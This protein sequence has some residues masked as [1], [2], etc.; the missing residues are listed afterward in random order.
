VSQS[1]IEQ[2]RVNQ[3]FYR[4]YRIS[5]FGEGSSWSFK[6]SPVRMDLPPPGRSIFFKVATPSPVLSRLQ[7]SR[8][9]VFLHGRTAVLKNPIRDSPASPGCAHGLQQNSTRACP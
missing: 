7:R 5:L 3:Q 1:E 9:T 8:S 4:S 2:I 6:L